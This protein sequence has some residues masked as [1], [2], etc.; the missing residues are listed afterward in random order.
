MWNSGRYCVDEA[1]P[2]G[3]CGIFHRRFEMLSSPLFLGGFFAPPGVESCVLLLTTDRQPS[4]HSN[5]PFSNNNNNNRSLKSSKFHG[6]KVSTVKRV[7]AVNVNTEVVAAGAPLGRK[8]RVAVIGG[9][10]AG[11]CAAE[12]LAKVGL[13]KVNE[14]DP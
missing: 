11:A 2:S 5:S 12:T 7:A 13:Y 3:S 1:R 10:P 4:P 6:A 14:V 9:G 8:L